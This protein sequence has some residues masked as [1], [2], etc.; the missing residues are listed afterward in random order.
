MCV[1]CLALN[2]AAPHPLCPAS[3]LTRRSTCSAACRVAGNVVSQHVLGSISY[4]LMHLGTRVIVVLGHTKCGAIKAS[5]SRKAGVGWQGVERTS[6]SR[7]TQ[8]VL[9]VGQGRRG[10]PAW[11]WWGPLAARPSLC[12]APHFRLRPAVELLNA[13]SLDLDPP[14]AVAWTLWFA[15]G[16]LC[17]DHNHPAA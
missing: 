4:A 5:V 17:G 13:T 1:A 14:T 2:R 10:S 7:G 15:G 6:L 12:R 11:R 16:R 9:W 8:C 3:Q